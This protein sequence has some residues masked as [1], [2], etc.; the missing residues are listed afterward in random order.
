MILISVDDH[1]VEPPDMF[2][3]HLQKKYLDEAPRLVHN[4][5]GSDTWQFRDVLI[6]NV[7]SFGAF[8]LARRYTSAR[9]RPN[10]PVLQAVSCALNVPTIFWAQA[11]VRNSVVGSRYR[12]LVDFHSSGATWLMSAFGRIVLRNSCGNIS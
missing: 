3:N 1:V 4:P 12:R 10:S 2:K 9:H 5:D 11:V 6:P 8:A 7:A